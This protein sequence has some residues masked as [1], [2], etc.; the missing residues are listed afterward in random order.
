M[1]VV[2]IVA[3]ACIVSGSGSANAAGRANSSGKFAGLVDIGS[4]NMYLEC[5]GRG[6]PTVV[7]VSGYHEAGSN[8]SVDLPG[9]PGPHVLPAVSRFTRVCTY[10]RPG[11]VAAEAVR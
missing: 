2:A 1:A 9:L 10:D 3:S 7:L 4:R 6:T 5:R 8:W 11:T